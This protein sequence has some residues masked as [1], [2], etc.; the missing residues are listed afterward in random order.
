[1]LREHIEI[2]QDANINVALSF[3]YENTTNREDLFK[4]IDIVAKYDTN[5]LIKF[6]T[7]VGRAKEHTVLLA[8][9]N[10]MEIYLDIAKYIYEKNTEESCY[11]IL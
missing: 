2:C 5:L 1:M 7:P 10:K 4:I 9:L 11:L 6:V 3:M 8:D